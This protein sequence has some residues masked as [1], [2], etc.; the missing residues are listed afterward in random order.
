MEQGRGGSPERPLGSGLREKPES[1]RSGPRQMGALFSSG[2]GTEA[3]V[4]EQQNGQGEEWGR[5]KSTGKAPFKRTK[6]TIASGIG[7]D[8]S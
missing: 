3:R 4:A 2:C 6:E 1:P 8:V 5:E 7:E